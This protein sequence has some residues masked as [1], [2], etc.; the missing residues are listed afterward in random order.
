MTGILDL[1]R[2]APA[3]RPVLIDAFCG[4][5]GAGAGYA[6]AGFHVIGVDSCPMPRYPFPL[7]QAD[8][9]DLIGLLIETGAISQ[10]AALHGSPPCQR[11]STLSKVYR[12]DRLHTFPELIEPA[13]RAFAATGLPFVIENVPGSPLISPVIL[14]GSHFGLT[15]VWPGVGQAGTS[16]RTRKVG[17]RRHR[18]FEA[19][20]FSL[21]DPGPHDHGYAAVPVYGYTNNRLY[22]GRGFGGE[23]FIDLRKRVMGISW[24][25]HEEL[26]EAVPP[27]Y[28]AWIGRYLMDSLAAPLT[29]GGR[30]WTDIAICAWCARSFWAERRTGRW[31]SGACRQA[32]YRARQHGA[33]GVAARQAIPES[34]IR[35]CAWCTEWFLPSRKTGVYCSGGCRQA[36]Y[37]SRERYGNAAIA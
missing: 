37:R 20:G 12:T 11:Y 7:I 36:A 15:S 30:A 27:A 14:C 17:L 16:T 25:T 8:V 33:P 6:Q 13:R 24:M 29:G 21:P 22:R 18:G 2:E 32:A 10:V 4:A 9:L 28:T 19:H 34:G 1:L 5:G 35:Q 3:G 23:T 31:C 26:N